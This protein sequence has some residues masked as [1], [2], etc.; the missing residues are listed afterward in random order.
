MSLLQLTLL[1]LLSSSDETEANTARAKMTINKLK[2]M[3][4]W[5]FEKS[6]HESQKELIMSNYST[7]AFIHLQMGG[8]RENIRQTILLFFK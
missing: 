2:R 5:K 8:I 6:E 7:D 1:H 3:L 4:I